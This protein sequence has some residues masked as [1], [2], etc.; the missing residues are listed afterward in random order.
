VPQIYPAPRL[1]D[2]A[3]DDDDV[4]PL[5]YSVDIGP[6]P[7]GG[8]GWRIVRNGVTVGYAYQSF[9]SYGPIAFSEEEPLPHDPRSYDM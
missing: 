5:G 6:D 3:Q 8:D 7:D 2:W 9:E 1:P 4:Q